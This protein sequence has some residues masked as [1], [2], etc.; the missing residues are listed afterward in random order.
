LTDQL[1][2]RIAANAASIDTEGFF[3]EEEFNWIYAEGLLSITNPGRELDFNLPKTA[4]LLQLLKRIGSA[5]LSV[6]RIYEGHVNALQMIHL[7]GNESQKKHWF[8]E[9]EQQQRLFGVWNTQAQDGV[10]IHDLGDGYYRLEGC[11]TFCSGSGWINRPLVTGE[12]I[13]ADK[14]GW[15]MFVLPTEKVKPVVIDPEFWKPL[16]MRA[17]ASF[18]IDFTGIE[19]QE[20]DLLGEPNV[21]YQQP[22]FGG[23]AIRFAAV[24]LGGAE[25]VFSEA[26]NFLTELNRAD[27]PFQKVRMAEIGFLVETGN[28]WLQQAG[29][30]TD[31]WIKEPESAAKIIAYA[32]MVRTAVEE[33][34]LRTMQIAERCVGARGMLRPHAFERIH[35]DLT[36]YLKQPGPDATLIDIGNYI[37]KADNIHGIWK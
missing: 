21:Y 6:G 32:G 26:K 37:L 11:K 30:N 3:P 34:C 19:I 10:K 18:K 12:L 13:S 2:S 31:E 33:I 16:G 25:A 28:L 36:L 17:S 24:Q 23:G 22:Y 7:H 27:D 14:T 15:Q 9:A 5:N 1:F 4:S 8:T 29:T 20:K 35:R